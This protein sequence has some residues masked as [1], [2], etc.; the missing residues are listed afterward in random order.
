[1]PND[2]NAKCRCRIP[3]LKFRVKNW[4]EY[5]AGLRR[6]GSLTMWVT[7]DIVANWKRRLGSPRAGSLAI[8]ISPSKQVCCN[9]KYFIF[10]YAIAP[11]HQTIRPLHEVQSIQTGVG[12]CDA[13]TR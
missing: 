9:A 8:R 6:R 3:K 12:P 11:D 10:S 1:M 13:A 7:D 2:Y 4:R 5:D